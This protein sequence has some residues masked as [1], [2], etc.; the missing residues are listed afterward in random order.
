MSHCRRIFAALIGSIDF[1]CILIF[2]PL[3]GV[4]ANSFGSRPTAVLG[5]LI[6]SSSLLISSYATS[7]DLLFYSYG[8]GF[9]LGTSLCY[10]QGIVMVSKYF[11]Y[12]TAVVYGRLRAYPQY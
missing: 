4:C 6:L 7:I 5:V 2:G 10:V 11:R 9:G 12:E 1:G 3:G 8:V